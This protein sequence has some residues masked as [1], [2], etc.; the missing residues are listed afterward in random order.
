MIESVLA[1]G[2]SYTAVSTATRGRVT[3]SAA[4]RNNCSTSKGVVTLRTLVHFLESVKKSAMGRRR[5]ELE[6][7]TGPGETTT[8]DEAQRAIQDSQGRSR[9]SLRASRWSLDS[10]VC[11]HGSW[12]D[13]SRANLGVE[14]PDLVQLHCPPAPVFSDPRVFDALDTL[15]QE[16]RIAAYGV[17][18]ETCEEALSAI[19][20]PHVATVQLILNVFRRQ[21]LDLV[22]PAA[23]EAGV[24]IIARVPLP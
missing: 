22:L 11:E 15:V 18:V 8:H 3:R 20:R 23:I 17:S 4:P 21:P 19:A 2:C 6:F 9:W 5:S 13:R 16:Q 12:A 24:G 7:P 1:C 14:V 10:P